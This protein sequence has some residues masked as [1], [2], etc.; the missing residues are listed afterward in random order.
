[1][2][3]IYHISLEF[4]AL[5]RL[6]CAKGLSVPLQIVASATSCGAVSVALIRSWRRVPQP[7][8]MAFLSR[9]LF[10]ALNFK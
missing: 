9:S 1:M 10:N 6:H 7:S 4:K 2:H 3:I 8:A 5:L